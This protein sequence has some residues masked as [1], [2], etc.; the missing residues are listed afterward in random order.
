MDNLT[1]VHVEQV[2]KE[3]VAGIHILKA[4]K[5]VGYSFHGKAVEENYSAWSE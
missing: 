4:E 5:E 3:V 1:V 2:C